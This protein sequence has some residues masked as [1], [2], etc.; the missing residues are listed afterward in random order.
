M[1]VVDLVFLEHR[2][3][4]LFEVTLRV[5]VAPGEDGVTPEETTDGFR[6]EW[7]SLPIPMP[8]ARAILLA[9]LHSSG[10]GLREHA[11]FGV[12][13]VDVALHRLP[14]S[15]LLYTGHYRPPGANGDFEIEARFQLWAVSVEFQQDWTQYRLSAEFLGHNE[16]GLLNFRRKLPE[17]HQPYIETDILVKVKLCCDVQACL[18]Q[19]SFLHRQALIPLERSLD[20]VSAQLEELQK[21]LDVRE[22]KRNNLKDC[23]IATVILAS[24][25]LVGL[26]HL[27]ALESITLR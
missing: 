19:Q 27:V 2:G 15:V 11:P 4:M 16:Q 6:S 7:A 24:A 9:P 23:L 10:Y 14:E 21:K 20:D 22:A 8:Q 26:S 18:Q 17:G 13:G 25:V 5:T 12:L 1:L 3:E